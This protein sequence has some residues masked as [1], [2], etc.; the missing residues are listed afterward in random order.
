[1]IKPRPFA[2]LLVAAIIAATSFASPAYAKTKVKIKKPP[3]VIEAVLSCS[4]GIYKKKPV[5]YTVLSNVRKKDVRKIQWKVMR[6]PTDR[7]RKV[8]TGSKKF[9]VRHKGAPTGDQQFTYFAEITTKDKQHFAYSCTV[10]ESQPPSSGD[11]TVTQPPSQNPPPPNNPPG[12][13]SATIAPVSGQEGSS[14]NFVATS[15]GS[16]K[17]MS[18]N[19]GDGQSAPANASSISHIYRDNGTY[20][21]TATVTYLDNSQ[22][23]ATTVATISNVAPVASI[24][25]SVALNTGATANYSAVVTD[26]GQADVAAGFT[27]TWAVN[28]IVKSTA[29]TLSHTFTSPGSYVI[30]LTAKDKDNSSSNIAVKNVTVTTPAPVGQFLITPNEKIPNFGASP[31]IFSVTSGDWSNINTWSAGRLPQSGDVVKISQGDVVVFDSIINPPTGNPLPAAIQT[32]AIDGI[33][34]FRP[35]ISTRLTVRNLLVYANGEL[36]I[37]TSAAPVDPSVTAEIVFANEAL[38]TVNDPAQY[39]NGLIALGKVT[40]YGA[41]K[42]ATFMRLQSDPLATQNTLTL[43]QAVSG[44]RQNDRLIIPDTRQLAWNERN[45]N[46]VGQWELVNLNT[47]ANGRNITLQQNLA[48]NHIGA[49]DEAGNLEFAAHVGNLTRNVVFKSA[50]INGVRGHTLYTHRADVDIHNAQF[51]GLGRTRIDNLDDTIF[52]GSGA[53]THVGTNQ[54]GRYSVHFSHLIG[55]GQP[56]AN[57]RQF[58]FEGNSV[59]CPLSPMPFRWGVAINDSHYGLVKN[60][61]LYNWAGG[62]IVT[63]YGNETENIIE[64]NFVVRTL[65]GANWVSDGWERADQR[66]TGDISVEGVGLWFRGPNNRVRN[67]VSANN[68][69]YGYTYF[70]QYLPNG[71]NMKVPAYQ[72]A[73]I[74]QSGGFLNKNLHATPILQFEG[75]EA[76][77]VMPAGMTFWWVG[78]EWKT[79]K[80]TQPSVIKNFTVWHPHEQGIFGYE[81]NK[82]VV[83][84]L[85]ARGSFVK[86]SQG[87]ISNVGVT[88]GDYFSKDTVIQ[89]SD[90]QGFRSGY[91]S[92]F[93]TGNGI[94]ILRDSYLKNYINVVTRPIIT[95]SYRSDWMANRRTELRGVIFDTPTTSSGY[96]GAKYDI[97]ADGGYATW[98]TTNL[99]HLD[100]LLV[101]DYN[102][103]QGDNFQLYYPEQGAN[104]VTPQSIYNS[105]NSTLVTASPVAGMTNLQNWNVYRVAVAG[106]V[107]T[108]SSPVNASPKLRGIKCPISAAAANA[109]SVDA[110]GY[111]TVQ[112]GSS[113]QINASASDPQGDPVT[114]SLYNPPAGASITANGN[115]SFTASSS[116]RFVITVAAT[117]NGGN[118]GYRHFVITVP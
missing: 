8:K 92:S 74:S 11:P 32:V 39:S 24:S 54:R 109:P 100:Q 61:V 51:V 99:T 106:A 22:T 3:I 6:S 57:G 26:A 94:Q 102:G 41:P 107:A 48:F 111:Q 103:V 46:F 114:F 72:G 80:A 67:N 33:L 71:G 105:D 31:T 104:D 34:A 95:S 13:P 96:L 23:Q 87:D 110:L 43:A 73:D 4:I 65:S 117:D 118:T 19:F 53:V 36:Q 1:M 63:E 78:S 7:I 90:I 25:G 50:N 16:I 89:Y 98:Q 29:A 10:S 9:S 17:S 21:V 82:I 88:W 83:D 113:L 64:H 116:G 52:N 42:T 45:T 85:V 47:I 38:D 68:T 30:N 12:T 20:S 91:E 44:W 70:L 79:P 58:T 37:G 76:Y 49:H 62:G 115:F 97:Y 15:S 112:L 56:Q 59:F 5:T 40:V 2:R 84:G 18:V 86:M 81:T 75:N 28:G 69:S 35:D 14:V 27:Y 60:N 101:Y 55:P 108:C 66:G 93:D 77:G